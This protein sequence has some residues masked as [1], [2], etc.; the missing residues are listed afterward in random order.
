MTIE[1][2]KRILKEI[3]NTAAHA[4][5]TGSLKGGAGLLIK[6]YNTVFNY[7]VAQQWIEN[8]GIVTEIDEAEIGDKVKPMDYVGCAA[9][10]LSAL[11][12]EVVD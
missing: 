3:K 7:A 9:G 5:L 12:E 6:A 11:L 2:A 4:S 1:K 10:L 8:I